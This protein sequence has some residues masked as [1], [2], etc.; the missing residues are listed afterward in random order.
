[1]KNRKPDL[2]TGTP[3]PPEAGTLRRGGGNFVYYF[4]QPSVIDNYS[5]YK[6]VNE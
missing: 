4:F 2:W 5:F 1:M 6:Y 3:R